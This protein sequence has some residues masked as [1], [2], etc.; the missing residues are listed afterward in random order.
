MRWRGSTSAPSRS[1]AP[2]IR[3]IGVSSRP[4]C[5]SSERAV[6]ALRLFSLALAALITSSMLAGIDTLAQRGHVADS[7]M[8]QAAQPAV[9]PL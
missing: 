5:A 2:L 8:A 3:G 6:K 1:D 7:L 4:R 9:K